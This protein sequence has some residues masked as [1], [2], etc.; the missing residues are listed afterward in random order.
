VLPLG[1][2]ISVPEFSRS[3][4][5]AWRSE[6]GFQLDDRVVVIF[7]SAGSQRRALLRNREDLLTA[8]NAGPVKR[9]IC[10]GGDR[11]TSSDEVLRDIDPQLAQITT[12]AGHQSSERVAQML[13]AADVGVLGYPFER[14][15]KSGVFMAYSLA[16]LPVL[17]SDDV[18]TEVKS[19]R[20]AKLV[21]FSES[22]ELAEVLG[23]IDARIFR[24][25]EATSAF[26]WHSLARSALAAIGHPGTTKGQIAVAAETAV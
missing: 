18:P 23:D 2:N 14:F 1:S 25:Q 20:E 8:V 3:N 12:V 17:V 10:V 5:D 19:F 7:G 26:S 22:I 11:D 9:I 13:V 4:R 24:H 21:R 6:L 16:G 15:G